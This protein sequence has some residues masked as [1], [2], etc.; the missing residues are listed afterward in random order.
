MVEE[1]PSGTKDFDTFYCGGVRFRAVSM[2]CRVS[3]PEL[4]VLAYVG[5]GIVHTI[6]T[7][8]FTTKRRLRSLNTTERHV[9]NGLHVKDGVLDSGVDLQRMLTTNSADRQRSSRG[10]HRIAE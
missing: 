5:K 9:R 4:D 8:I 6:A 2:E 1:Q 3:V 7:P 10:Q